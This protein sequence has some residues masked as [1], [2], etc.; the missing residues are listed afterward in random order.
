ME[1]S[2]NT[3]GNEYL[4]KLGYIAMEN[5][6]SQIPAL[7]YGCVKILEALAIFDRQGFNESYNP[8]I[9]KILLSF[10]DCNITDSSLETPDSLFSND[11]FQKWWG[12][13]FCYLKVHK[14]MTY[15]SFSGEKSNEAQPD[16]LLDAVCKNLELFF[17]NQQSSRFVISAL[18]PQSL[19]WILYE[20][21][22]TSNWRIVKILTQAILGLNLSNFNSYWLDSI[23]Y[24]A[25]S[26]TDILSDFETLD[27]FRSIALT[28]LNL[29]SSTFYSRAFQPKIIS[30]HQDSHQLVNSIKNTISAQNNIGQD[31]NN[32]VSSGDFAKNKLLSMASALL[33]RCIY[34]QTA[35]TSIDSVTLEFLYSWEKLIILILSSK[36]EN[37]GNNIE[38]EL[39]PPSLVLGKVFFKSPYCLSI[40]IE[41]KPEIPNSSKK[42]EQGLYQQ[43]IKIGQNTNISAKSQNTKKEGVV[44]AP[45]GSQFTI[46][47]QGL[48]KKN[49]KEL[50]TNIKGKRVSELEENLLNAKILTEEVLGDKEVEFLGNLGKGDSI[51]LT[52]QAGLGNFK[53]NKNLQHTRPKFQLYYWMSSNSDK[54]IPRKTFVSDYILNYGMHADGQYLNMVHNRSNIISAMNDTPSSDYGMEGDY[55]NVSSSSTMGHKDSL[56][57]LFFDYGMDQLSTNTCVPWQASMNKVFKHT[58]ELNNLFFECNVSINLPKISDFNRIIKRPNYSLVMAN[59]L[60]LAN[61]SSF[62][63][64][65]SRIGDSAVNAAETVAL[66]KIE[67]GFSAT[68][69]IHLL[70][71]VIDN[72]GKSWYIGDHTVLPVILFNQPNM[73]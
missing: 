57:S 22:S 42:S 32:Q 72:S 26:E 39:T 14:H 27:D 70:P 65:F 3:L 9:S 33:E 51:G 59:S 40:E 71:S 58:C 23:L 10:P 52:D 24:L 61:G 7:K 31:T 28:K 12:T 68:L 18:G 56:N 25:K 2:V 4:L 73:V 41:T 62:A 35:H 19:L 38:K 13:L 48:I 8:R 63:Q 5:L 60:Y 29:I 11:I 46:F 47:V 34:L 30:F 16:P 36:C 50:E 64:G 43:N 54:S 69:Y 66:G 15:K 49:F 6:Q 20:S 53:A 37:M 55:S 67:P 17:H 44:K 21:M 45:A 1:F